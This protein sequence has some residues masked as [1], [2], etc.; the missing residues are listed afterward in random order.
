MGA[1]SEDK[2]EVNANVFA[3]IDRIACDS[4]AQCF[5]LGE[6]HH[7]LEAGVI[8]PEHEIIE[9]GELTSGQKPGRCDENE[10]TLCDLTGVGIQDTQIARLAYQ[11]ATGKGFGL[12]IEN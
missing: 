2:Q 7:A 9:L 12:N 1:D 8:S 5:R 6:L 10:I 4:K 11:R 3:R